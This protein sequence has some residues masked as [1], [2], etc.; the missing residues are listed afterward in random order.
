MRV[1]TFNLHAGV[2]GWGRPTNALDTATQLEA[3]VLVLQELWR[4][5]NGPDMV[6]ELERR[7]LMKGVFAPLARCERVSTGSAGLSWQPLSAHFTGEHGLYFQ[8]HRRLKPAQGKRRRKVPALEHG[9]WGL[10]LFTSL[11][12]LES[13]IVELRRLPR[14]KVRRSVI[15]AR[16]GG[17]RDFYVVAVHGAHISHGS[18]FQYRQIAK[19]VSELDQSVPVIMAGDFNCWR[20]LLRLFLPGWKTLVR[21]R[22]WPARLPHSQ[23]DHVLARGAWTS[24]GGFSVNGGSDHRALVADVAN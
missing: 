21:S 14:E 18:Y 22:T 3:D 4:G 15:L 6:D 8:E 16:L 13:R 9:T 11:P 2:D 17:E 12:V 23:I 5:D 1:A 24:T 19:I 7:L 10:G 20:P